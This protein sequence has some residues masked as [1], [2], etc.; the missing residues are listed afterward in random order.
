MKNL[1]IVIIIALVG[2][3][4]YTQFKTEK[5]PDNTVTQYTENL[6]TSRDK[7]DEAKDI[8]NTAIVKSAIDQ[9][10]GTQGRYPD[11]L[12]E[13]VTKGF[14]SKVPQGIQYDKATGE[15]KY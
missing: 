1:V 12:E 7:A 4:I 6:K 10:R 2:W 15:V 5:K 13:L 11:N 14:I 9:F 3:F 8:A